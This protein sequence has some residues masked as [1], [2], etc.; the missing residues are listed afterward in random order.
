M[1]EVHA[2]QIEAVKLFDRWMIDH[3]NGGDPEVL[4]RVREII[5][6]DVAFDAEL[7]ALLGVSELFLT[8]GRRSGKTVIMEGILSS[9]NIAVDGSMVWTVTPSEAYHSEPH[10]VLVELLPKAWYEYNGDPNYTFYLA[11]GSQHVLRSGHTPGALKKGKAALV[12]VNE[13][14]QVKAASYINARGATIDAGG[15]TICAANPPIEGDVGTWVLDAV[16]QI[17]KAE[18][19]AAEHFFCDP[20]DNPHIDLRKILALRSS[21]TLH[22]WETQI[23]GRML[24]L[25]DHVLYTWDRGRNERA[26]PDFGKITQEFLTAHEGDRARWKHL[27][28]VDVQ[29]FPW[30][31]TGIF[32]IYRDPRAPSDP[33]AGLLWM[34]DEVAMSAGDEVDVCNELKRRGIDGERSLVVMDASCEWQQLERDLI[35]Q[36]P[37]YK[38]KGSMFIF[39]A[40]GFPHVVPPDR[41][42]KGNPDIFERIRATNAT[43][44][45]A[46]DVSGLFIDHRR[47]PNAAESAR[48][49]RMHKGKPSRSQQAAH[50]GDV[51]GYAVW[52]FFPR[53]GN[54]RDLLP[55][56]GLTREH[57]EG[58]LETAGSSSPP[59]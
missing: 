2:A 5:E 36:R 10:D 28:V 59:R 46:D 51:V 33:K 58:F 44:R 32:D 8:G 12:G 4:A 50:F 13:A 16:T 11:N 38:G 53:R 42:S 23:R 35:R 34:H 3:L 30:V 45:P 48:K 17:E 24:Q 9:Y 47:C 43:I 37:N 55:S 57:V 39:R 27:I 18:R 54:A 29:R 49:W 14:Q 22:Q 40:N 1:I 26:A 21:M 25:P 20:L 7:G 56:E 19:P 6:R 31:A 52:R 15:F 41:D